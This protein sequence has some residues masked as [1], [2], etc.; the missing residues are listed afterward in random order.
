MPGGAEPDVLRAGVVAGG[1]RG[2]GPAAGAEPELSQ[3][4]QLAALPWELLRLTKLKRLNLRNC[5]KLAAIQ[6]L[7]RG[8]FKTDVPPVFGYLRDLYGDEPAHRHTV[9]MVLAGPTMAGK[10]SLLAGLLA[11]APR[12]QGADTE[13][14]VGLAIERLALRETA[15]RTPAGQ[16]VI[17][18]TY[19]AGNHGEYHEMH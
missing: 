15:G 4:T 14:T 13:R 12:L 5:P 19:D 8:G 3:C 10:S 1:D 2:A 17:F 9:K 11:G 18:V 6:A 16:P 7:Q